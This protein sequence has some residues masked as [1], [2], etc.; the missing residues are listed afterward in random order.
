[1]LY[2]NM[3]F[4]CLLYLGTG[5]KLQKRFP[6]HAFSQTQCESVYVFCYS[7]IQC[8]N[9]FQSHPTEFIFVS[10]SPVFCQFCVLCLHHCTVFFLPAPI[11]SS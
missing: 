7:E 3:V 11:E 8:E 6:G 2:L 5:F 4:S 1:M 10:Y 9:V